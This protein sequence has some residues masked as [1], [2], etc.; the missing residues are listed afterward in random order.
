M[1]KELIFPINTK[2]PHDRDHEVAREVTAVIL[3]TA[4]NLE[5]ERPR[6]DEF[7]QNL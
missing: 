3:N 7:E 1:M 4:S 5:L 2:T 6:S